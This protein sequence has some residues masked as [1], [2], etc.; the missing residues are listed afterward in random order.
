MLLCVGEGSE[1]FA[2]GIL[3]YLLA[4]TWSTSKQTGKTRKEQGEGRIL[5]GWI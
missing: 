5:F 3:S 4:F 2:R 1:S